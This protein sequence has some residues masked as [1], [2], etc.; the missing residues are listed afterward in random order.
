MGWLGVG[1]GEIGKGW[2]GGE[3]VVG[4]LWEIILT[5]LVILIEILTILTFILAL[6]TIL[7][8]VLKGIFIITMVIIT[9]VEI[10]IIRGEFDNVAL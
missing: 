2:W 1:G 4:E 5:I 8:I 6:F 9:N 3:G 10:F 7:T